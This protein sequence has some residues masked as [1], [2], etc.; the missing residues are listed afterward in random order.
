MSVYVHVY[1]YVCL[2]NLCGRWNVANIRAIVV[3]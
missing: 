3:D 2:Y 1:V